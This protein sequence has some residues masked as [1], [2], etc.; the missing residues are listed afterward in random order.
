WQ[1]HGVHI[2][3]VHNFNGKRHLGVRIANQVLPDAVHVFCNHRVLDHLH[4]GFDLLS[5]G[6]ADLDIGLDR[7]PVHAADLAVA[8]GIDILL[9]AIVLGLG[10]FGIGLVFVVLSIGARGRSLA[11][12][13]C[14]LGLILVSRRLRLRLTL[15]IRRL[16]LRLRRWRLLLFIVLAK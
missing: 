12:I 16:C 13:G 9:T 11:L 7:V 2:I 5:V 14:R 4:T 6:F 10:L 3:R 15:V 8:N 1:G